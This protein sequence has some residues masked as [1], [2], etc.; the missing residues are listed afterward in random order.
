MLNKMLLLKLHLYVLNDTPSHL[1]R[2]LLMLVIH[3]LRLLSCIVLSISSVVAEERQWLR[4]ALSWCKSLA[5]DAFHCHRLQKAHDWVR[6]KVTVVHNLH[7]LTLVWVAVDEGLELTQLR[8]ANG[9]LDL[10]A[11]ELIA[12]EI[13]AGH[14]CALLLLQLLLFLLAR[15]HVL[16]GEFQGVKEHIFQFRPPAENVFTAACCRVDVLSFHRVTSCRWHLEEGACCIE[17]ARAW[18]LAGHR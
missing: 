14:C 17:G 11:L 7:S 2:C 4:S 8:A 9:L 3:L 18:A 6:L 13:W 10:A 16:N 15:E 12:R 1:C 5:L